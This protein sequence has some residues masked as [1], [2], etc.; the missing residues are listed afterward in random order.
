MR[1][2]RNRHR[3]TI[4]S[5]R[6]IDRPEHPAPAA[7]RALSYD[8]RKASLALAFRV[9]WVSLVLDLGA[10]AT[11]I[12]EVQLSRHHCF[13]FS[14][15]ACEQPLV[16]ESFHLWQNGFLLFRLLFCREKGEV[17]S[18]FFCLSST[19]CHLSRVC[20]YERLEE[21]QLVAISLYFIFIFSPSRFYRQRAIL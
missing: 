10:A 6:N 15:L 19:F 16:D 18:F 17:L 14:P 5:L 9:F 1:C 20:N 3:Y 4:H 11:I 13:C 2:H 8:R 12:E 21:T 7:T